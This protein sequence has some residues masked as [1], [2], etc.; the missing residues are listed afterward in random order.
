MTLCVNV[1][2]IGLAG[3]VGQ[4]KQD[5]WGFGYQLLL[6]NHTPS[7]SCPL[8]LP[9]SFPPI[10]FF[11]SPHLF[12]V[13]CLHSTIPPP[14][15]LIRISSIR[16]PSLPVISPSLHFLL[17]TPFPQS[18]PPAQEQN[19][20]LMGWGRRRERKARTQNGRRGTHCNREGTRGNVHWHS[21]SYICF[22]FLH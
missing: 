1:S 7:L 15:L 13:F 11:P 9:S 4:H 17:T 16:I 5:A 21:H 10:L 8:T 22:Y 12:P 14:H 3:G 19:H 2:N 6:G 20:L 18:F